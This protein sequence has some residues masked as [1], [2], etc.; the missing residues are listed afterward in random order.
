M[1]DNDQI[2]SVVTSVFPL[3]RFLYNKGGMTY[4]TLHTLP[5]LML[6]LRDDKRCKMCLVDMFVDQPADNSVYEIVY[7]LKNFVMNAEFAIRTEIK[8]KAVSIAGIF[9]NAPAMECEIYDMYGIFFTD[10]DDLRRTL[11]DPATMTGY[12]LRRDFPFYGIAA[13][14]Y[15]KETGR[16]DIREITEDEYDT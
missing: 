15:N 11:T 10:N 14:V 1:T 3:K 9:P 6:F 2:K 13:A 5:K 12:P 7:I 8:N 4:I 16:I